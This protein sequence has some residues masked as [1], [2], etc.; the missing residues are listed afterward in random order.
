MGEYTD[1]SG[2]VLVLAAARSRVPASVATGIAALAIVTGCSTGDTTSF[3]GEEATQQAADREKVKAISPSERTAVPDVSG[4]TLNG[5]RLSLD[6]YRGDVVVLN[7]WASWCAPCRDEIPALQKLRQQVTD[8]GVRLVGVN[9]KDSKPNAEAFVRNFDMS[10]PS[11]Y[12]QP[13]EVALAFRG[14]VPPSALPSTIV[15]D[16]QGRVAGRILGEA[17]YTQLESMVQRVAG[18][19]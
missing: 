16:R 8:Q 15:I 4:T 2:G 9:T 1:L 6:D 5:E 18:A 11:L 14:T 3:S 17:S 19:G 13:G 7:F 10:Y 12:D